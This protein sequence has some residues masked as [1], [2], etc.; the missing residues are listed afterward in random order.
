VELGD[1]LEGVAVDPGSGTAYVAN[2]S[3]IGG[4][5]RGVLSTIDTSG[6]IRRVPLLPFRPVGVAVHPS[7]K[8]VYVTGDG[9]S[10]IDTTN[11][12]VTARVETPVEMA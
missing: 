4:T 6:V 7:G 9:V 12:Q 8:Y 2:V 1:Y 5:A 3:L 11:Y 10:V